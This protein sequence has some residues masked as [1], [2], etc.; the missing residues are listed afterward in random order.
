MGKRSPSR[1]Q[2]D[3][4]RSARKPHRVKFHGGLKIRAPA[5]K[6]AEIVD[7]VRA[8]LRDRMGLRFPFRVDLVRKT[9]A[10][11]KRP[12]VLSS[13]FKWEKR[14][15]ETNR[16]ATA[17]LQAAGESISRERPKHRVSI[18]ASRRRADG[19]FSRSGRYVAAEGRLSRIRKGESAESAASRLAQSIGEERGLVPGWAMEGGYGG[20]GGGDFDMREARDQYHRDHNKYPEDDADVDMSEWWDEDDGYYDYEVD[21]DTDHES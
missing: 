8:H 9:K 4:A 13:S 20:A 2:K 21:I 1:I 17:S 14:S 11:G 3:R 15:K 6:E 10:A 19:R 16:R 18:Q 12:G 7:Q 5:G